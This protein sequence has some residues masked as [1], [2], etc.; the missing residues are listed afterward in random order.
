MLNFKVSELI[1]YIKEITNK[2]FIL[3]QLYVEG[4]VSNLNKHSNGNAYFT[5]KD[6]YCRLSCII[7]NYKSL[8]NIDSLEDGNQVRLMGK[9]SLVEAESSLRLIANE[10]ESIGLGNIYERFE[11]T[12]KEL[13]E[14]GYFSADHKKTIPKFSKKIGAAPIWDGSM[15]QS[16]Y[17]FK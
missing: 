13:E 9:I 12:K 15:R 6:D 8:D 10:V 1:N 11:K 5:V 2:D 16:A 4:E 3:N 17:Y 7:Y 14:L